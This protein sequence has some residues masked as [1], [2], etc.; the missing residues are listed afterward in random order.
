MI[1]EPEMAFN[2][3]DQVIVDQEKPDDDNTIMQTLDSAKAKGS[4]VGGPERTAISIA[5]KWSESRRPQTQ[6]KLQRYVDEDEHLRRTRQPAFS[7]SKGSLKIADLYQT[8]DRPLTALNDFNF[9]GVPDRGSRQRLES[10]ASIG[11]FE[12]R[13]RSANVKSSQSNWVNLSPRIHKRK[14]AKQFQYSETNY[15]NTF[16]HSLKGAQEARFVKFNDMP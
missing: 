14:R 15:R 12:Q 5:S 2:D 1:A 9:K 16:F 3:A 7:N 6:M 4:E 10:T 13:K 8:Q 11:T